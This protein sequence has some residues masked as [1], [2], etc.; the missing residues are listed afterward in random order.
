MNGGER[1][2]ERGVAPCTHLDFLKVGAY[3]FDASF[4]E[5]PC[6]YLHKLYI[7]RNYST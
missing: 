2:K 7:A 1:R 5:K 3:A 4:L 6:K